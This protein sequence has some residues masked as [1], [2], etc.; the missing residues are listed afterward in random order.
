MKIAL[1][2]ETIKAMMNHFISARALQEGRIQEAQRTIKNAKLELEVA[3]KVYRE[4]D[5]AIKE[6]SEGL[7]D[8][9][10]ENLWYNFKEDSAKSAQYFTKPAKTIKRFP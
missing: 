5:K 4:A 2:E 9:T 6:L 7:P 3:T 8:N 1:T 10:L